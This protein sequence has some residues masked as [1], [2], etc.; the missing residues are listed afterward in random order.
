VSRAEILEAVLAAIR[1]T[2]AV[3]PAGAS[4]QVSDGAGLLEPPGQL[5][6]LGLV[7][8]IVAVENRCHAALGRTV[9]LVDALQIPP[10]ESPFRTVQSLVDHLERAL[11]PG[12]VHG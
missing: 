3:L 9:T 8:L 4:L 6:S 7:N 5:D 11:A 12:A 2:N 1:E 10:A